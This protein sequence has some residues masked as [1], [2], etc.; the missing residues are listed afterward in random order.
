MLKIVLDAPP[1][2]EGL[3]GFGIAI[4]LLAAAALV[5]VAWA[6]G[7]APALALGAGLIVWMLAAGLAWRR[8]EKLEGAYAGWNRLARAF[9]RR[10][11]AVVLGVSFY[12][13]VLAAAGAGR[14]RGLPDMGPAGPAWKPRGTLGADEYGGLG[15]GRRSAGSGSARELARWARGTGRAWIL[16]LI[17]FLLLLDAFDVSGREE[18]PSSIYTLY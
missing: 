18:A 7:V 6:L 11:A 9:G 12:L 4:G 13:V 3:Q 8:P 14:T 2:R 5:L 1:D 15:G 16:L 17:P 10:A